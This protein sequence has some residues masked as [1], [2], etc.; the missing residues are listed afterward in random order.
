MRRN[1]ALRCGNLQ[2]FTPSKLLQVIRARLV[3]LASSQF[4][5]RWI[6]Y[7]ILCRVYISLWER[8]SRYAAIRDDTS[9]CFIK[10]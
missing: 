1:T 2:S 5:K 9:Y 6:C 7:A 10:K 8:T 4:L 3:L